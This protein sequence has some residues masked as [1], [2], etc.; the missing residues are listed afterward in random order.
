[1]DKRSTRIVK[2]RG[3]YLKITS[4]VLITEIHRSSDFKTKAEKDEEF[5]Y[6]SP[7]K[8][9]I[10]TL[11]GPEITKEFMDAFFLHVKDEFERLQKKTG[12][13]NFFTV[14]ND[15]SNTS[16]QLKRRGLDSIYIPQK[17][18]NLIVED[19]KRFLSQA[20]AYANRQV[21][22]SRGYLLHGPPGCGKSSL[23]LALAGEFG[24]DILNMNLEKLTSN[25]LSY[26]L[27][28]CNLRRTLIV[29]EDVDALFPEEFEK[30]KM[31][32]A[33]PKTIEDIMDGSTN[34][35]KKGKTQMTF[36]AFLNALSGISSLS[37]NFGRMI[38]MTTNHAHLIPKSLIRPQRIDVKIYLGYIESEEVTSMIKKFF[39]KAKL[40]QVEKLKNK[41]MQIENLTPC[42]L[43]SY[44]ISV[45]SVE[46]ALKTELADIVSTIRVTLSS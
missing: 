26:W 33:G 1:L 32:H 30:E 31:H 39:P 14:E 15:S 10:S 16:K 7:D 35:E 45:T 4:S 25:G 17:T 40:D 3:R 13:I 9:E 2:F 6:A 38:I 22:Y 20:D 34:S 23:I 27:S 46:Q 5:H 24:F 37:E 21:P 43:E 8:F 29:F 19:F 41:M 11:S 28:N 18:K 36:S 12:K 44:L 42:E